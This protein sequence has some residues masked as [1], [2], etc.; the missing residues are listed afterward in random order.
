MP[1][2]LWRLRGER[3]ISHLQGDIREVELE[4]KHAVAT[5]FRERDGRLSVCNGRRLPAFR[6]R[7]TTLSLAAKNEPVF[8]VTNF[9]SQF[10]MAF[11]NGKYVLSDLEI[12]LRLPQGRVSPP[13]SIFA[14]KVW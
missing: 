10:K 7:F 4:W 9:G 5:R 2:R 3:R 13:K 14:T 12:D 1:C 11:R 6:A 8:C